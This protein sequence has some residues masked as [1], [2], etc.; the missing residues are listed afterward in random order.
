[1]GNRFTI[2]E[3]KA[4]Y[5]VVKNQLQKRKRIAGNGEETRMR[6]RLV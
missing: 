1:M 4:K 2:E 3:Y 6:T 5:L